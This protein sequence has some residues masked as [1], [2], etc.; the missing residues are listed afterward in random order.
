MEK[1][2]KEFRQSLK[3]NNLSIV[4]RAFQYFYVNRTSHNGLGGFS[5]N[6]IVRRGMSKATSDFL[7]C[8]DRFK[9]MHDRLSRVIIMNRDAFDI[10]EKYKDDENVFIYADPPYHQST[11][12]STRYKVD[13][14]DDQHKRFIDIVIEAKCKILISGY[15]CEEYRRL[16]DST[17]WFTFCF[18]VKT[19]DGNH[20]PKT[21][22]ECLWKNYD[23][24]LTTRNLN[25]LDSTTNMLL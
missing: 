25:L 14:S 4:D 23:I 9:E 24:D 12:T 16:D 19:I 7:S 8:I 21:K 1:L 20:N 15:A 2:R 22:K 6:C 10:L 11:R 3:E 18:D 5:S 17:L 13:F